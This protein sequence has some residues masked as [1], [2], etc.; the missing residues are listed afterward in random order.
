MANWW[1]AAPLIE[2]PVSAPKT[3]NWWD[4][5]PLVEQPSISEDVAK[6]G[7]AGVA[8]GSADLL[9]MP[10]NIGDMLHSGLGWVT[11]KV[12]GTNTR[13]TTQQYYADRNKGI[14]ETIG[15]NI[16]PEDGGSVL[17]SDN[18]RRGLSYLT[19]GATDYQPQTT[20]GEYARTVGEFAPSAVLAPGGA[21]AKTAQAVVPALTSETAGQLTEDTALEPYARIL[22]ALGGGVATNAMMPRTS[23]KTPT[24]KE[25][26]AAGGD[27]YEQ[28]KPI[29]KSTYLDNH[30]YKR[31]VDEMQK[32]ADEYSPYVR[33]P[34]QSV[35]D[36]ERKLAA[37]PKAI[38]NAVGKEP[39]LWDLEQTRQG[40]NQIGRNNP[41]K[42]VVGSAASR[43]ID[44][45][46]SQVDNLDQ[47]ALKAGQFSDAEKA[48]ETLHNARQTYRVGAK[49]ELIDNAVAQAQ[50]SASGVENG[51]R[52]EFR[53][54]LKEKAAKNFS[55]EELEAISRVAN[56]SFSQNALRWLG[57]FGVPT[58]NG[59]N[60]LGSV[61]GALTGNAL[62]GP[63]GAVALP[64]AG[65]A[66]KVGASNIAQTN[67][68]IAS[69]LVK[70][71]PGGQSVY[72]QA[73]QSQEIARKLAI[74]RALEQASTASRT[75]VPVS[76]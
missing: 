53:K 69:A 60:F 10:S 32:G 3:Q 23:L 54:L 31:I 4:A 28:G 41:T 70:S 29:L 46:D 66:A 27:L 67:A 68:E 62:G 33:G 9:A 76:R 6:A 7:G 56:G 48:L 57:G 50:N 18:L 12:L 63:V 39:S 11:D 45:L 25:I 2:Q 30:T 72:Q 37:G 51:L 42:P 34:V 40:L 19:G 38:P 1:E 74:A 36:T 15:M 21:V 13:E 8:R 43:V 47:T 22:G 24:A 71:G 26:K 14:N 52:N 17:G 65:A 61:V 58:D 44:A 64:A 59:R 20:A 49:A 73:I 16:F 55:K 35:V 5:A 75:G